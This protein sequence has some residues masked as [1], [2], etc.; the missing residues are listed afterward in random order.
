MRTQYLTLIMSALILS[1]LLMISCEKKETTEVTETS[2][3][4]IEA[5]M[6]LLMD[7][8]SG[9]QI[10]TAAASGATYDFVDG[11]I[12]HFYEFDSGENPNSYY[13]C[14][15]AA[16]KCVAAYHGVTKSLEHIHSACWYNAASYRNSRCTFNGVKKYCANVWDLE[17]AAKKENYKGYG[18]NFK[19]TS[20]E[21]VS[22]LQQFYQRC[23]DGVRYNK[24]A[25]V[26]SW[27]GYNEGHF[28][29]V[30]GYYEN[31]KSNGDI[32]YNRSYLFLRDVAMR[33]PV[34]WNCDRYV[35][36]NEFYNLRNGNKILF[37]RP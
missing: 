10:M 26:P 24:P 27:Y 19:N 37:V 31:R 9:E 4:L 5:D 35:K 23:K 30:T 22:S 11:H 17:Y 21:N 13:W 16:L 3:A 28:Y 1:A 18:F 12:P 36:V 2:D 34:Y 25:I 29:V 14:G 33:N 20:S 6:E 8:Q 7:N 32:D 15:Q